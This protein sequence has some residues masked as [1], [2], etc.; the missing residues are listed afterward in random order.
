LYNLLTPISSRRGIKNVKVNNL[1]FADMATE[2]ERALLWG[3]TRIE[4]AGST[5]A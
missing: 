5:H 1:V 3:E 2:S 4:Q